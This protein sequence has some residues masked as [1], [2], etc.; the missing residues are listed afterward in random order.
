VHL[1]GLTNNTNLPGSEPQA[2]HVDEGQLWPALPMAHPPARLT[3]NIPL[4]TTDEANGAIELWPGTH[5]DTRV[6]RYSTTAEEGHA[7]ALQ[8]VRAA[9]RAN[10]ANRANRRVGLTVP[11]KF[12]AA[13]REKCPPVPATTAPGSAIIRDPRVWHRGTP[14]TS[15]DS[16][17]MLALTYDPM[18]RACQPVELPESARVLMRGIGVDVRATYVDHPVDHLRRYL[19]STSGP[20]RRARPEAAGG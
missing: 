7:R 5:L 18:W 11:D 14:N 16:R 19:P 4:A 9:K 2:V 13:R 10:V 15:S 20:L 1:C 6:C 12:L 17:F 3:V 8:Y